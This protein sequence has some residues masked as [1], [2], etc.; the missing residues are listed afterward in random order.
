MTEFFKDKFN[1]FYNESQAEMKKKNFQAW[2]TNMK[3]GGLTATTKADMDQMMSKFVC[4]MFGKEIF[5]TDSELSTS[6]KLQLIHSMM[7]IVFSHRY[8]KGD[9]FI[10][11]AIEAKAEINF[12]VVRDVMYKYSKKAQDRYFSFPVESFLFASFA[13]SDEGHSFLQSKPDNADPEKLKRLKDDLAEL[14]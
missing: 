12:G 8:N 7:M 10:N 5:G 9:L 11:E 13:L 14:K 1:K 2:Q 3:A 4:S 6:D